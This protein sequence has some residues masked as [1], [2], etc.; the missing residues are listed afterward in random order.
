MKKYLLFFLIQLA[1]FQINAQEI[2]VNE[3][4][5]SKRL[6]LNN[7]LKWSDKIS[8]RGYMQVRYNGLAQTNEKLQCPQCDR[9]WGGNGGFFIRRM[10]VIIFGQLHERVFL[11]IQPDFASSVASDNLHFTQLRD[12]YFDLGFDSKNEFRLRIGQSK[13][14]FGFENMQSSQN[15]LPLDRNDALNSA[16]LNERDLGFFFYW[17][18]SKIRKR[19]SH[20]VNSGLK[21]SGDYGVFGIGAYNGQTANKPET[22]KSPHIVARLTY[23]FEVLNQIIEPSI[24]AYTGKWTMA[25][26]LVSADVIS[27]TDL[28]YLDQRL[29]GTFVLYPQPFGL[30]AE[31]NVGTGPEYDRFTNSIL[32]RPLKGGYV[33]LTYKKELKNGG[34]LYPFVRM[35]HYTGGKKFELDARSYGVNEYEFGMEWEPFKNFELVCMYT[36]S[37][38]R[39]EDSKNFPNFQK[40]SLIRI[41]AQVNF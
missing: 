6:T 11:Y 19:F 25:R 28:T 1:V 15:R 36:Y 20:L 29:A 41:Q 2:K 8:I 5:D 26:N 37:E 38:R 16:V 33:T 27:R 14:P 35:Q 3:S 30:F 32:N 21:G 31:Y 23:P 22:N 34:L 4:N 12:A 13:V 10:R 39:F 18:P 40:G 9:S 24:Q 7:H 17:A